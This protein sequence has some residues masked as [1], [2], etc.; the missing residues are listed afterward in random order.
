MTSEKKEK[1]L[2][3]TVGTTKFEKL[4]Q[5]VNPSF[6]FDPLTGGYYFIT[7]S[8]DTSNLSCN[9]AIAPEKIYLTLVVDN[10]G[11]LVKYTNDDGVLTSTKFAQD[12]T[13]NEL[14]LFLS[15]FTDNN[16]KLDFDQKLEDNIK[17]VMTYV[18]DKSLHQNANLNDADFNGY[19]G[20]VGTME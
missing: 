17:S 1:Q 9:M 13:T 2:L 18:T 7:V 3:V 19:Y 14:D 6:T 16:N 5:N 15:I 8:I 11:N 4:I 20:Y 12:F 10:E